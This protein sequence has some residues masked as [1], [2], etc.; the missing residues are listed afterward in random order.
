MGVSEH[1]NYAICKDGTCACKDGFS[2]N[3]TTDSKCNCTEP[4]VVVYENNEAFCRPPVVVGVP[5]TQQYECMQFSDHIN[6]I[7]CVNGTCACKDGFSGNAT[8]ESKCTCPAPNTVVYEMNEALC[9]PPVETQPPETQ[10]PT[11]TINCTARWECMGVTEHF[12]YVLCSEGGICVCRDGFSGNATTDAKCSCPAPN[13]VT[14]E[15]NEAS[16]LPPVIT[17]PPET[18]VPENIT[19]A[20]IPPETQIPDNVTDA[21]IPPETEAPIP[22]ETETPTPIN[23]TAQW[24]CMAVSDDYN[25][26]LCSEGGTCVC[27]N[28][29]SGNATAD[30]KCSCPTPNVVSYENNLALCKA[31]EAQ[32]AASKKRT[33]M[34]FKLI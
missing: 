9:Q 11:T 16:C 18:Q 3:A 12:N 13:T 30:S 25:F 23:C 31:P 8:A 4:N 19:D 27:R 34:G 32:A 6:Y 5:C 28:G 15:N 7:L 26:V 2:G 17:L 21:P 10:V 24:E 14:Y 20:P 22:P 29:F 1:F 33:N